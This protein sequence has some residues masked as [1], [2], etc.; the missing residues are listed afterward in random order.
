MHLRDEDIVVIV[1][2]EETK[3]FNGQTSQISTTSS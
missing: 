1:L 3:Q 2:G